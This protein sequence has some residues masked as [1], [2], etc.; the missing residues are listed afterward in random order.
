MVKILYGRKG[1]PYLHLGVPQKALLFS[2][3]SYELS[4]QL[5]SEARGSL[6]IMLYVTRG[7]SLI[8]VKSQLSITCHATCSIPFTPWSQGTSYLVS[9]PSQSQWLIVSSV[10]IVNIILNYIFKHWISPHSCFP[11]MVQEAISRTSSMLG[12]WSTMKKEF[13]HLYIH[14]SRIHSGLQSEF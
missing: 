8:V 5:F 14:L 13:K 10:V 11:F 3:S 1:C 4:P 12:K 6:L 9:F 2:L 7:G